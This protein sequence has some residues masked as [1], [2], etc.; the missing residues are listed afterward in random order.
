MTS[1]RIRSAHPTKG[2]QLIDE[3]N[4]GCFLAG[5]L[6]KVAHPRRTNSNEHL[7]KFGTGNGKELDAGFSCYRAGEQRLAGAGRSHQK[8]AFW[9]PGPQSSIGLGVA[10]K[11]DDF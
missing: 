5:L 2:I 3:D 11:I 4:S 7:D 1:E 6:E 9:R 10:E 8:H